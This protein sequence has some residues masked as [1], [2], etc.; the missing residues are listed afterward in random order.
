[1]VVPLDDHSVILGQDFLKLAKAIPLPHENH[2]MSLDGTKTCGVPMMNRR[3]LWKMPR[4]S[5]MKMVEM[6]SDPTNR[7]WFCE[8]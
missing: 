4:M 3:K 2:L 6:A 5:T 8:E 7:R 1:M